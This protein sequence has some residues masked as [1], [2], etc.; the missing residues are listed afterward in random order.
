MDKRKLTAPCG[1]D[2]FNCAIYVHNLTEQMAELI[3]SKTG[4][5]KKEIP[6]AGC[7]LQNGKHFHLS[8]EGCATFNCAQEKNVE[9][10]C[11]CNEFP[12]SLLAPLSDEADKYPHNMK[13]FNLCRIKK[14]GVNNWIEKEAEDIRR[15]Y[16]TH[17]FVVGK[18]QA[19]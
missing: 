9:F 8:P 7:R 4:V 11:D 14:I 16:F 15:K 3:H 13:L 10:C 18:G 19:E 5:S 17:K 1:L 12:C 6:C 2:C